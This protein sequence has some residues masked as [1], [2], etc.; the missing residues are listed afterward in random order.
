MDVR[1]TLSELCEM[2]ERRPDHLFH[3]GAAELAHM[4]VFSAGEP[5]SLEAYF[6]PV[7]AWYASLA[8]ARESDSSHSIFQQ[9][10]ICASIIMFVST[11]ASDVLSV[12]H[13]SYYPTSWLLI[14]TDQASESF[15]SHG[16]TCRSPLPVPIPV[17][18]GTHL[19]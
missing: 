14:T 3:L 9:E 17:S 11:K 4:K 12:S 10:N 7:T 16:R 15:Y 5:I 2:G 19:N 6:Q 8:R 1:A 18:D 13:P